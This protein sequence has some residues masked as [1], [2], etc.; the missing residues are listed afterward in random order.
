[1]KIQI[2]RAP[3]LTLWAC[4]VAERCGHRRE[5][6]LTLGKA[7]A[8]YAAYVKAKSLG[9]AQPDQEARAK[10]ETKP[11]PPGMAFMGKWIPLAGDLAAEPNGK[12]INHAAVEK[13]L[14]AKFK[15]GLEPT[16][17]AMV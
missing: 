12:P 17:A 2:N 15:D 5:L 3:V 13:Y 16:R 4:V 7:L 10:R 9:I 14:A 1:M 8:G 6:A 11:R